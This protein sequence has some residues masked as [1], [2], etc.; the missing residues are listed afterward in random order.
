[1]RGAQVSIQA[2]DGVMMKSV[3]DLVA[4]PLTYL[5]ASG[6]PTPV[7]VGYEGKTFTPPITGPW[8]E[9]SSLSVSSDQRLQ[10]ADKYIRILQI[11]VNDEMNIGTGRLKALVDQVLAWY[12]PRRLFKNAE[13]TQ[14]FRVKKRDDS[15]RHIYGGYQ[16]IVVSVTFDGS[17]DREFS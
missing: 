10:T 3:V 5:A 13:A 16:S 6:T 8:L 15:S 9:A 1:V 14:G 17:V 11:D 2:L 7:P 4:T 12:K